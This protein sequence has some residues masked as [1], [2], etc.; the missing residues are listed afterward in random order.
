MLDWHFGQLL[1]FGPTVYLSWN[2]L[3]DAAVNPSW[4]SLPPLTFTNSYLPLPPPPPLAHTHSTWSIVRKL[5]HK[6]QNCSC[7]H[8]VW[9]KTGRVATKQ[10]VEAD[11]DKSTTRGKNKKAPINDTALR[12]TGQQQ[13]NFHETLFDETIPSSLNHH[14]Q[15]LPVIC[16]SACIYCMIVFHLNIRVSYREIINKKKYLYEPKKEL[17]SFQNELKHT[18]A[19]FFFF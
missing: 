9:P 10:R 18:N 14:L 4:F 1:H 15:T 3:V 17:T 7:V 12:A 11:A 6:K 5:L 13:G 2:P 19:S 16:S 8:L